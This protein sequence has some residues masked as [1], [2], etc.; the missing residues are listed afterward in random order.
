MPP[1]TR[2]ARIDATQHVT[3]I[4]TLTLEPAA[5]IPI[6]LCELDDQVIAAVAGQT[7]SQVVTITL[8]TVTP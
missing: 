1:E 8:A 5:G 4:A 6:G 7:D 3:P 2:L